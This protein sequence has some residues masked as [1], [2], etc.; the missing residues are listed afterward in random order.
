MIMNLKLNEE[1]SQP[2]SNGASVVQKSDVSSMGAPGDYETMLQGMEAEARNHVRVEQQLKL[3]IESM[4]FKMEESE[5][6]VH[7]MEE[8]S[9]KLDEVHRV[10]SIHRKHRD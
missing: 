10:A 1:E 5:H 6:K 8:E 2:P 4:Q 9:K 7:K 3:H